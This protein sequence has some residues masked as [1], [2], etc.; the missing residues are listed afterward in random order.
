MTPDILRKYNG[1]I[2]LLA[3]IDN[4]HFVTLNTIPIQ[5]PCKSTLTVIRLTF[6]CSVTCVLCSKEF[7]SNASLSAHLSTVHNG[8]R[9]LL[10]CPL[11]DKKLKTKRA[12]EHHI[13][14]VH[15][16]QKPYTCEVSSIKHWSDPRIR[17][18]YMTSICNG[19]CPEW[20][21]VCPIEKVANWVDFCLMSRSE[22]I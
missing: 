21:I 8:A 20:F 2:F 14:G 1:V 9:Q 5:Y 7:A 10:Q 15:R 22:I 13:A 18:F 11:C 17:L 3:M 16:Y 6:C 12:M 4:I 19:L